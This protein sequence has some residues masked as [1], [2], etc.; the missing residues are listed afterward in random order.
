MARK[1]YKKIFGDKNKLDTMLA[2]RRMGWTYTGLALLYNVDFSSIYHECNKFHVKRTKN[3][4][5][6]SIRTLLSEL[7]IKV[8]KDKTYKDY[9]QEAGYKSHYYLDKLYL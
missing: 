4:V 5:D 2:L 8:K 3:S 6:F 9:L 1:P 7:D